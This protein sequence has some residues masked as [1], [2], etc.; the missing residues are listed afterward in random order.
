MW[1][2][3]IICSSPALYAAQGVALVALVDMETPVSVVG[4]LITICVGM[5]ALQTWIIKYL[6]IDFRKSID[7]NTEAVQNAASGRRTI[8]RHQGNNDGEGM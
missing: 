7:R 5:L 1:K 2:A 3:W 8:H 4:A 6:L